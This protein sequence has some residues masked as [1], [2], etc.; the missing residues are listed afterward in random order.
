MENAKKHYTIG[1]VLAHLGEPEY[2]PS[3]LGTIEERFKGYAL[4]IQAGIVSPNEV[5]KIEG[6]PP[7]P[8]ATYKELCDR[9]EKIK[10]AEDGFYE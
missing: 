5:R 1:E 6:L 4:L 3:V 8:T 10:P 9:L 2:H 7:L